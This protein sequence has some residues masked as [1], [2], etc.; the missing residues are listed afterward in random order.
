MNFFYLFF[1][2][3]CIN[4]LQSSKTGPQV[5]TSKPS[6]NNKIPSA[7]SSISG[8]QEIQELGKKRKLESSTGDLASSKASGA[9]KPTTA[10]SSV[11]PAVAASKPKAVML[12][13]GIQVLYSL[14][15]LSSALILSCVI[16]HRVLSCLIARA[17]L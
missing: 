9:A 12:K 13:C 1:F 10:T 11:T 7:V 5:K 4:A 2:F 17:L 8:S 16:Y 6:G 15:F 3:I 14:L